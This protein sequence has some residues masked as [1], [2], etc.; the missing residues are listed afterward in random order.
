MRDPHSVYTS[1]YCTHTC[2]LHWGNLHDFAVEATSAINVKVYVY[3]L[4]SHRVSRLHNLL[5]WF[6]NAFPLIRS[7]LLWGEFNA[8]SAANAIH[9]SPFLFHLVPITAGWTEVA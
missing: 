1:T 3:S 6:G 2:S 7:H 4:I 5:S 9:N 8:F